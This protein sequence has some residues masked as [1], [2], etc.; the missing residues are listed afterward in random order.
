MGRC[1]ETRCLLVARQHEL[2][3]RLPQRFEDIEILF[4]GHSEYST[5]ALIRERGDEQI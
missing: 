2:D 3:A 5:D 1:H 4:A